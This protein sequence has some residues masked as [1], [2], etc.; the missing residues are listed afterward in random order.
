MNTT[1]THAA[2]LQAENFDD[3]TWAMSVLAGTEEG[4]TDHAEWMLNYL[5]AEGGSEA[6]RLAASYALLGGKLATA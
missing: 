6:I 5:A 4:D 1:T 3:L 2:E